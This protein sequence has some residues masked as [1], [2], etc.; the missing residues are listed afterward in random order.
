MTATTDSKGRFSFR[1][2]PDRNTRYKAIAEGGAS[3]QRTVFVYLAGK[4][5]RTALAH[6]R[7]RFTV[8]LLGPLDV[9]Y[10]GRPMFFYKLTDKGKRARRVARS[11][12]LGLGHG[13]LKASTVVRLR[14]SKSKLLA[15]MPEPKPDAWGRPAPID[16][17]CGARRL[18][19]TAQRRAVIE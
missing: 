7:Y 17:V 11:R 12:L 3:A 5:R 18:V 6:G 8:K 19:G 14:S 4:V 10:A 13:V 2:K 9:P 15:C 1:V 16:R